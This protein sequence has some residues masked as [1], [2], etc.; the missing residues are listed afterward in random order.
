MSFNNAHSNNLLA[1]SKLQQ[2]ELRAVPGSLYVT[3][4]HWAVTLPLPPV[5]SI[6]FHSSPLPPGLP[7]GNPVLRESSR[8][9]IPWTVPSICFI[10]SDVGVTQHMD[11]P[12]SNSGKGRML[13]SGLTLMVGHQGGRDHLEGEV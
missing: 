10:R 5:H 6:P 1:R 9:R 13:P 2:R 11:L 8:S 4:C 12:G 3:G 7:R